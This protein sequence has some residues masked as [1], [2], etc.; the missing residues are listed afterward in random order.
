MMIKQFL[1]AVVW[2]KRHLTGQYDVGEVAIMAGFIRPNE[3]C[4]DIGAHAGSWTRP[5]SKLVERGHIYA[6]EA[7]PYYAKVL[8]L[9]MTLLRLKNVTVVNY[10]VIDH[11]NPV[12]L[13]WR[14][15]NGKSLTGLTHVAGLLEDTK[16]TITINSTTLDAFIASHKLQSRVAFVK[17]DVE[18]AELMVVCGAVN[19]IEKF[20]P[21]FYIEVESRH[22]RRYGY[23]AANLFD[24]FG[25]QKYDAYTI[26]GSDLS[27]V[28]KRV[29]S[30]QGDV[31]FVPTEKK[32]LKG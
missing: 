25:L 17:C 29:Y 23:K 7:L 24:F 12:T 9:T 2:T 28:D 26:S 6:F 20:R 3:I 19:L 30:G 22:C 27:I 18:G 11:N 10:A 21:I 15:N 4:L 16:N 1:H 8:K 14:D 32:D 5:L 31:L 13:I